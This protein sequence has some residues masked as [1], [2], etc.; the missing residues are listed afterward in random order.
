M[1]TK[2]IVIIIIAT[3]PFAQFK[4]AVKHVTQ[5]VKEINDKQKAKYDIG[6]AG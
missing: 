2:V 1:N 5:S 3:R 4:N 6:S